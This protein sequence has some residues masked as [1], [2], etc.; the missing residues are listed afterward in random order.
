MTELG[1]SIGWS[2]R[3]DI[4]RMVALVGE[5]EAGGVDVCWVIDSQLAMRDGFT[6]LAVLA[7]ETERVRLGPGVTNLLTRHETVVASTLATLEHLAPGRLLAG[8]GAGDSA[9][10]PIGLRPQGI[11]DLRDGAVRLRALLSGSEVELDGSRIRLAAGA[12]PA[13]PVYLAASQPRMLALAGEVA[14]GVIVMGP[15]NPDAYRAQIGR[16][17][18]A[19]AVAGRRPEEVAID[20]WVTMAVG[21]SAVDSVRSWASAQARWLN[22]WQSLPAS[23]ARFKPELERAAARYDFADHLSVS[24]EHAVEVP[25]ELALQL[26]IAGPIEHCRERL[27]EIVGIGADRVTIS[28]MSGGRERRLDDLLSVW[29][30]VSTG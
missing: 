8:I 29:E 18:D 4:D 16:I 26:A 23:L 11:D 1:I 19:A 13:P 25:D 22:R 21:N 30:G 14:D 6:L 3:E 28:L 5:A 24:A 15:A 17:R 9:V 7:R 27:S 20:L 12:P 2:A 10:F